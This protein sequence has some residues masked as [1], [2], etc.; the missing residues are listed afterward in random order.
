VRL[1]RRKFLEQQRDAVKVNGCDTA[2]MAHDVVMRKDYC[3]SEMIEEDDPSNSPWFFNFRHDF[4]NTVVF[5]NI[6]SGAPFRENC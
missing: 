5:D 2:M 6:F 4:F 1:Q 3:E